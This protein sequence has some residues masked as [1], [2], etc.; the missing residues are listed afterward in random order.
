MKYNL[1]DRNEVS[2]KLG[3]MDLLDGVLPSEVRSLANTGQLEMRSEVAEKERAA[4]IEG[5]KKEEE[6]LQKT[7]EEAK[8][9]RGRP[10]GSKN[11]NK[12]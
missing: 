10:K 4:I 5:Q 11:K 2:R 7:S 12:G 6:E 9:G 3:T 1:Y 8:R